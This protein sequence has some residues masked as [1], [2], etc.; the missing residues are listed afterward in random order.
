M[1]SVTML[2]ARILNALG[3]LAFTSLLVAQAPPPTA[4][5]I[6]SALGGPDLGT[7]TCIA[8]APWP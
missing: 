7:M 3:I 6:T 4:Y 2:S 5:T 8:T 1:L